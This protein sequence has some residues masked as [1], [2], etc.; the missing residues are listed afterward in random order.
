M[1]ELVWV[2]IAAALSLI[3]ATSTTLT[4][5]ARPLDPVAS[6]ATLASMLQAGRAQAASGGSVLEIAPTSRGSTISLYAGYVGSTGVNPVDLQATSEN[7]SLTAGGATATTF[8]LAIKSDGTIVPLVGS[9]TPS[10]SGAS[11]GAADPG[12]SGSIRESR[13][14]D[15]DSGRIWSTAT[16]M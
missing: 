11:I 13:T 3:V 12:G 4:G 14:L 5:V 6:F 7:L 2:L 16:G 8:W 9:A 1:N 15:C 10:C